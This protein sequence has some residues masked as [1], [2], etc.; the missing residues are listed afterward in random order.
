M[1][2]QN[3]TQVDV[4][5]VVIGRNEGTRLQRCLQSVRQSH[6]GDTRH[7]LIYVDS[8]SS[9]DSVASAKA[10]GA[11]VIVLNDSSP[12]AAKARNLGWQAARGE[13]VLFLDGDTELHPAFVSR[14][15]YTLAEPKLC[16]AWGHRRESRPQQSLYTTVLDLDWVYPTGR[17]L[18]FGG[19]VLVRRCALAQVDGFD[20]TLKAGEEPEL[21]AR[22]RATGW[23]IEHI[24]APMTLHDLAVNSFRAYWL[25]AYRSGIAYAEVAQRMRLRGDVL[26]QHESRR[27]FRH[28]LL[29]SASPLLLLGALLW[30][31][32]LALTLVALAFLYL[33][34]TALRCAWKA[35][36]Q[37]TLCAQYAVHAH[38]QKIP[39]LFGQLKWRQAV[40]QQSE[41]TLVD[42][43]K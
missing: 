19:D 3:P 41:I 26:W 6:W 20:P 24:D 7:E 21:C 33:V 14:A 36:G 15:L 30:Q 12:C 38:F 11:Q 35:P 16:A 4:S 17:S 34:R 42:Y 25:R 9:D 5:V 43:K 13:Y 27:D 18:Y 22:L 1:K 32:A 28:G 29:F 23:E 2:H 8:R 39:A 40:R 31:P 37:W 10:L